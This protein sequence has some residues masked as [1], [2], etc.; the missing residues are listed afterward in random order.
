MI[1]DSARQIIFDSGFH[2]QKFPGFLVILHLAIIFVLAPAV[3]N[4]SSF[5][6]LIYCTYVI[7]YELACSLLLLIN[8][9]IFS[10]FSVLTLSIG[11]P[12]PTNRRRKLWFR[13]P[14]KCW[15]VCDFWR[16]IQWLLRET[17]TIS[18]PCSGIKWKGDLVIRCL[19]RKMS[20]VCASLGLRCI[21][22]VPV[23]RNAWSW[24]WSWS[25]SCLRRQLGR[26]LRA[27][28]SRP[29]SMRIFIKKKQ[30]NKQRTKQNKQSLDK[31]HSYLILIG[32]F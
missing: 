2:L 11:I 12:M 17:R 14:E 22:V 25:W 29:E 31:Y 28:D 32:M 6:P 23:P 30:T 8:G 24:S 18:M 3:N 9:D 5:L 4:W 19:V 27:L 21:T 16:A 10:Y 13:R 15:K 20:R 7:W 26:L 1:T